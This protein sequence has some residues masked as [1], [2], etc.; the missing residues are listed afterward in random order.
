MV[1]VK[2]ERPVQ[3][4]CPVCHRVADYCDKCKMKLPELSMGECNDEVHICYLCLAKR[5]MRL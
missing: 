4:I 3:M 5:K 2:F 1:F